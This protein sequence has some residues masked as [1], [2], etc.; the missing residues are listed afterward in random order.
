M[1]QGGAPAAAQRRRLEHAHVV[2]YADGVMAFMT[3]WDRAM[4]ANGYESLAAWTRRRNLEDL[5]ATAA[6][7]ANHGATSAPALPTLQERRLLRA[8]RTLGE[9]QRRK[10]LRTLRRLAKDA[11]A[12]EAA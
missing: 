2:G 8:F 11:P 12:Q 1:N 9:P 6:L 7:A 10:A 5:A 4:R 3:G